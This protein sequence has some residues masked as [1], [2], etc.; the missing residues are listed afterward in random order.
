MSNEKIKV[1]KPTK[2]TKIVN[3]AEYN[4]PLKVEQ[5]RISNIEGPSHPCYGKGHE[6][7][8]YLKDRYGCCCRCGS[9]ILT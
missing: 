4:R 7:Y 6:Y 9:E 2:I 1:V 3:R 5:L 8:F